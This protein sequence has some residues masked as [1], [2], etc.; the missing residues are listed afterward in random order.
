MH[1][2]YQ[3]DCF[4]GFALIAL[5]IFS[6]VGLLIA[7]KQLLTWI[8]PDSAMKRK[9]PIHDRYGYNPCISLCQSY[10]DY[11]QSDHII[12]EHQWYIVLVFDTQ[13]LH[14]SLTF[15]LVIYKKNCDCGK[16]DLFPSLIR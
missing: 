15:I 11:P 10:G 7:L 14:T 3:P 6:V 16:I 2:F 4:K 12:Y 9:W 8:H 13:V 1:A 5:S